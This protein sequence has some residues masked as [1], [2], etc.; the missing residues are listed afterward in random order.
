MAATG[1]GRTAEPCGANHLHGAELTGFQHLIGLAVVGAV[2]LL[3]IDGDAL[4]LVGALGRFDNLTAA[5]GIDAGR[6]FH[7][8]VFLRIDRGFEVFGVK[9]CGSADHDRVE[10]AGQ[11]FLVV[12]VLFGA[13]IA[14]AA[15]GQAVVIDVADGGNAGK[16]IFRGDAG[17]VI[18]VRPRQ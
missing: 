6:L 12:L 4:G 18:R 3:I 5:L 17:I 1:R 11:Q 16:F 14:L 13:G 15:F 2:A 7:E 9:K 8:D 10:V